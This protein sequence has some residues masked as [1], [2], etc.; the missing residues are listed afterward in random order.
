MAR[1][2]VATEL[3]GREE[4]ACQV[5]QRGQLWEAIVEAPP[6]LAALTVINL[7]GLGSGQP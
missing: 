5:P 7:I 3:N 2:L 1:F 6:A 4:G